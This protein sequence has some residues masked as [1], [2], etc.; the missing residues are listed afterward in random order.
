MLVSIDVFSS[1]TVTAAAAAAAHTVMVF[2]KKRVHDNA[3]KRYIASGSS[4]SY[5]NQPKTN[6]QNKEQTKQKYYTTDKT[7]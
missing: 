1:E 6:Q 7:I 5:Q 3:H 4:N 2:E